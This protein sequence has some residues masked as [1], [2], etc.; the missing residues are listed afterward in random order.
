MRII[1]KN[2]KQ[3]DIKVSVEN[4]DDLW[5]LTQ[6]IAQGDIVSGKTL[7]KIKIGGEEGASVKK[8]FFV[9]LSVEKLDFQPGLL[10]INGVIVDGPEDIPKGSHH[11]INVEIGTA[12]AIFKQHWNNYQLKTLDDAVK[13]KRAKVL[14]CVFDREEAFF[15][16]TKATGYELISKLKGAVAK[17]AV[18]NNVKE[19]FYQKIIQQLKEYNVRFDPSFIILASPAFWKEELTA[20]LKD[21]IL[22]KKIIQA[23]CA[24]ADEKAINEVLKRDEIKRALS[25]ERAVQ[26]LVLVE[27]LLSEVSK[28]GL[29]V[30]GIDNVK[31]AVLC[32]AVSSLLVSADFIKKQQE[33]GT[34]QEVNKL[35]EVVDK[36]KGEVHIISSEHDGGRQLDGLG[37]IAA[38]LRFKI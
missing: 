31:N 1:H 10:R 8:T 14:I 4:N 3:G 20:H 22:K 23:S 2:L 6:I 13:Q 38:L 33:A 15:A 24:G 36:S 18:E 5:F 7:R 26:E 21:E 28:D 11:S 9:G 30:Y 12:I 25:D 16:L 34:F 17:K 19:N 29:A 32:K 35:M 27:K 37:G